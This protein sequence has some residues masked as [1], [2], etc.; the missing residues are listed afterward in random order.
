MA[1]RGLTEAEAAKRLKTCG[2]NQLQEEK[3]KGIFLRFAA[4]LKDPL[5]FILLAAAAV[6]TALGEWEDTVI[7]LAVVLLNGVTGVLQEGKARK[8]LEALKNLTVPHA[9]VCR[10]GEIREIESR[11]LVPGDLVIL[12]TGCQIPA[13]IRLTE[14][15]N[16]KAEE[17]ALTGESVPVL[18]KKG[19]LVCQSSYVTYGRG[20]GIV[21]ATGMD[22]AIGRIASSLKEKTTALTPLQR[23]L[24]ELGKVLSAGALAICFLLFGAALLQHRDVGEMFLTAISLAVAAVPEGLPA[25]VTIVLALSVSRMVRVHTIVRK[26]PA[27]ETLGAV[28]AVCSDKTGT[29]TQNKMKVVSCYT[30]GEIRGQD[31]LRRG[32][33]DAFLDAL[34][35][36]N[37]AVRQG[38]TRT[39]DPS[40]LALLD[41]AEQYSVRK[42]EQE[43]GQPRIG[44]WPFDSERKMMSTLHRR[45]SRRIQYTKGA[46]DRVLPLCSRIWREGRAEELTG[47]ERKKIENALDFMASRALRVMA[48]AMEPEAGKIK[49][50]E[51]VFLGLAGMEDPVRPG[52]RESVEKFRKAGVRTVMITGDYPDTALAI[53][54]QLSIAEGEGQCMTGE[55]LEKCSDRELK[56]RVGEIAVFA[57]VSP[58]HKVRIVKALQSSGNLVAM[59]GDGVNDAP[60]LKA[61]D[62]GI[63]MGE[64][65]TDVAREAADMVLTDDNFSTIEKAMAEGR[66]IYENIR[67]SVIFLLSSNFGEIL[68]MFLSVLAGFPAALKAGHILWINLITDSL[69]ALA[70]GTDVQDPGKLMERPPRKKEESIFGEGGLSCTLFYGLL[71]GGVS[72]AAFLKLPCYWLSASGRPLSV[73]GLMSAFGAPGLLPRAQTYAFTV[74]GISQLFHA[75]G[76]RDVETSVFRGH[77][78][79]PLMLVSVAVGIALQ[80]LVTE[81]PYF[82]ELFGT[83][84][85][86]LGEWGGLLFMALMPLAAH[87]ILLLLSKFQKSHSHKQKAAEP[88]Q[89]Q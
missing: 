85:L 65:G 47:E 40:E 73:E 4:Q 41:L 61:A 49:E 56:R 54:R 27:V 63:A 77:R 53:A 81:V 12:K 16:L 5:I 69:P 79:N 70:L 36:C 57:R 33:E 6:S 84:Q 88:G 7:I 48:F 9:Q 76:M 74:L 30:G 10:G 19:D 23:K 37:D 66:G 62:I 59:T 2:P 75:V 1:E 78:R 34:T 71:I 13:D 55:N 14:S 45:G 8:A 22:T 11:Q 82:I 24:A 18:K 25:I 51:L 28:T 35:L 31:E 83:V 20:A 64:K 86:S 44:E 43:K 50:Q 17:S 52:V 26:L 3:E 68:T 32:R 80:V 60:S 87:E 42:E 21:E 58:E 15:V 39:G 72:L 46:P 29:L 38:K 67:K 89:V